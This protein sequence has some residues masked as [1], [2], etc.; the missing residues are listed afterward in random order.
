MKDRESQGFQRGKERE[1]NITPGRTDCF[2][3]GRGKEDKNVKID[4]SQTMGSHTDFVSSPGR[5]E[6]RGRRRRRRK[7]RK[8]GEEALFWPR[9]T[10][11]KVKRNKKKKEEESENSWKGNGVVDN[12]PPGTSCSSST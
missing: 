5:G 4:D 11:V 1:G 8:L 12:D 6:G 7:G 9:K 3:D 10:R 2:A